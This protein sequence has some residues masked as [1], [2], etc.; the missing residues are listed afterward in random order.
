M[1]NL[2][3]INLL[4]VFAFV[5]YGNA[6]TE[7]GTVLLG[8]SGSYQSVEN[9]V[10]FSINPNIGYFVSN[11]IAFGANANYLS[12][13]KRKFLGFGPYLRGYFLTTEN[14]SLFGQVGY[15]Y[16]QFT[17]INSSSS[18]TGYSLALGYAVFLN[19]SIA[20][21]LTGNYIKY[22]IRDSSVSSFTS[23]KGMFSLGVGFQIHLKN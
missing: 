13:A 3:I 4:T 21:E 2:I 22:D 9:N 19:R 1:K 15:N 11:K 8:G 23:D 14:G 7:K 12:N 10:I 16:V 17:R 20:L 6:Q 5:K 18:E